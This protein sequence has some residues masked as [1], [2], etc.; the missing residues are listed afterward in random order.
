MNK[1]IESGVESVKKFAGESYRFLQIC[2]K[3]DMNG[4]N[5]C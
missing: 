2:E 4:T 1:E 5:L 3:P